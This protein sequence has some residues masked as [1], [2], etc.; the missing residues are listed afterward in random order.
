MR[1]CFLPPVATGRQRL[2]LRSAIIAVLK[3]RHEIVLR[4]VAKPIG[5]GQFQA[6]LVAMK[7][8]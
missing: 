2:E 8:G 5:E 1:L 3:M 7:T 4:P 6:V